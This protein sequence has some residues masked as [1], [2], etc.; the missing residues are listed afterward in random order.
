MV[1]KKTGDSGSWIANLVDAGLDLHGR[2]R[3][4]VDVEAQMHIRHHAVSLKRVL[5]HDGSAAD[6]EGSGEHRLPV[7]CAY[8]IISGQ[9]GVDGQHHDWIGDIPLSL[10][11][12][13]SP[14]VDEV[15]QCLLQQSCRWVQCLGPG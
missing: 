15:E 6:D 13:R 12:S 4:G 5:D 8:R 2:P 11:H 14:Q 3:I 1:V 10:F 9:P 7:G